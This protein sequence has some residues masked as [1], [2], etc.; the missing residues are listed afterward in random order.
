MARRLQ[1]AADIE[2]VQ[3]ARLAAVAE[4]KPGD[5]IKQLIAG[6]LLPP[7]FGPLPD[8]SRVKIG[9]IRPGEKIF[10]NMRGYPGAFL[11]VSDTPVGR[12]T[13]AEVAEYKKFVD[14][15]RTQWGRIDPV[16]AAIKRN[17]LAE[18]RERVVVDVLM[19][20]FAPQHFDLLKQRLGPADDRCLA[21]V[22]GN[23]AALEVVLADQRIFAGLR[24]MGPPT[25]GGAMS[26]FPLGKIRDLLVG[27]IGTT[28]SNLGLLNWLNLGIPPVS[29]AAGYAV[30][31]LGGFRRQ[32]G[33]FIVFSFQRDV[34][35]TVTPQLHF[36][37]A[38]RPAQLRVRV[39]DV[40]N[41]RI[42]PA[43]NDLGYA[44]TRETCLGNIRLLHALDQQLH[45]APAACRETAES[46]LDAKLIC[47]L[48]GKF[49]LQEADGPAHWTSTALQGAEK[50]GFLKVHAP[51]GY[52]TPPLNWFRGLDL[53]A[54][55]IENR[56]S[57]HAEIIMQMPAKK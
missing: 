40:S 22:P 33:E 1:A 5:T 13:Q 57:A 27:Y 14:F 51:P 47:P 6:S 17:P 36:Q 21:T 7:E 19:S 55:M 35:E 24:D 53:D 48:G 43:L 25:S 52:Q 46:L 18:N 15:Y 28:G 56:V 49:V 54:T 39:D 20:P 31:P 8:D 16:I 44:R 41:A 50:G 37:Q 2:L 30:S 38:K 26:F 4:G 42:T 12:V 29:D 32:Y 10:D 45:V 11:P 3:L 34:L 9:E 23:M